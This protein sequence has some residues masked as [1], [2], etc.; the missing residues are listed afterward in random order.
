MAE[1]DNRVPE[2]ATYRRCKGITLEQISQVTKIG[3]RCLEA[4]ENGEFQKLPGGIYD[5]NY[6]RQY[7]RQV[8][9]DENELLSYYYTWS[10]T[11]SNT[12]VPRKAPEKD[13]RTFSR[14]FGHSAVA[15]S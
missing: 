15:R 11:R 9:T 4:I 12:E 8:G 13:R 2:L 3:V 5:T 7:A 6:I 14:L 1:T 10:G